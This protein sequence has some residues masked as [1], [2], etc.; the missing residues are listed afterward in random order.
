[1]KFESFR[2]KKPR[3][4]V[5]CSRTIQPKE[6]YLRHRYHGG[7][8]DDWCAECAE[9]S[10]LSSLLRTPEPRTLPGTCS[11]C[12]AET[13]PYARAMGRCQ[14]C[15]RTRRRRAQG[16]QPRRVVPTTCQLP[17][18]NE[19]HYA[20]DR[21]RRCFQRERLQELR[22]PQ[23]PKPVVAP[24]PD[25]VGHWVVGEDVTVIHW[26]VKGHPFPYTCPVCDDKILEASA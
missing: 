3:T 8:Q 2:T 11:D 13:R 25:P 15:Q 14:N 5:H 19:P 22:G 18:C 21:C 7:Q 20:R 17:D 1:M 6:I 10:G 26:P 9:G 16:I 12:G 4:C 23:K 24:R